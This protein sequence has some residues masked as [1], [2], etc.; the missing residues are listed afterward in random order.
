MPVGR[1]QMKM[2]DVG[3]E[4]QKVFLHTFLERF[5]CFRIGYAQPAFTLRL[6]A[7]RFA[8]FILGEIIGFPRNQPQHR[9]WTE[10]HQ[11]DLDIRRLAFPD[12]QLLPN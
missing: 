11:N 8:V 3:G 6:P 2:P 12:D 10:T 4:F 1:P 9:P 5:Q 7:V